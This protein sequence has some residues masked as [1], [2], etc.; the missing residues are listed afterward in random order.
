MKEEPP[1]VLSALEQARALVKELESEDR[2][3]QS[4]REKLKGAAWQDFV[5]SVKKIWTVKDMKYTPFMSDIG[6]TEGIWVSTQY[7]QAEYDAFLKEWGR[8]SHH[9]DDN[10]PC[11][12]FY[13]RTAEN[14]LSSD[15]GGTYV[16]LTPKL[17]SDVEWEALRLGVIA[18]KFIRKIKW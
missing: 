13:F 14:I 6:P 2:A 9:N 16:L 11:G 17:C 12:M 5:Q 15:G 10:R 7:P 4:Q 3:R 18:E 8:P 1:K